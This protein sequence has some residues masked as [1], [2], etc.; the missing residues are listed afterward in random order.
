ME[1]FVD[2]AS[3]FEMNTRNDWKP[4]KLM[5]KRR[6][7]RIWIGMNNKTTALIYYTLKNLQRI[8]RD[9]KVKGITVVDSRKN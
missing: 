7:M 2:E 1:K 9:V 6:S 3:D 4:A 5:K 8:A